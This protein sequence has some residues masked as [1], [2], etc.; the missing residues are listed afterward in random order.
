LT[1]K[2]KRQETIEEVEARLGKVLDALR[3]SSIPPMP[4]KSSLLVLLLFSALGK[5]RP[6][7]KMIVL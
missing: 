5:K 7:M 1:R 2:K 6:L 3:G 4:M